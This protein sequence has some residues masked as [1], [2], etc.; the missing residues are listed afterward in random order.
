MFY[1][2]TLP[3]C[4]QATLCTHLSDRY[5]KASNVRSSDHCR[6]DIFFVNIRGFNKQHA[7][8]PFGHGTPQGTLDLMSLA[9]GLWRKPSLHGASSLAIPISESNLWLGNERIALR[10]GEL[11][12]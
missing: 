6:H 12:S 1:K 10:S 11:S 5:S 7:A 9:D 8:L 2:V 3:N 4:V